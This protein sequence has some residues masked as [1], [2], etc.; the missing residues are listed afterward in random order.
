M[1]EMNL[2]Q[3]KLFIK[4]MR[5]QGY[6]VHAGYATAFGEKGYN[7]TRRF[8]Q[9]GST[10]KGGTGQFDSGEFFN[11]DHGYKLTHSYEKVKDFYRMTGGNLMQVKKSDGMFKNPATTGTQVPG[12]GLNDVNR[13][14]YH[15]LDTDGYRIPLDYHKANVEHLQDVAMRYMRAQRVK[16]RTNRPDL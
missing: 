14:E 4:W 3:F 8:N 5:E 13:K 12:Y 1:W 10:Y 15:I 16:R 6:T 2:Y 9:I 11:H 7:F